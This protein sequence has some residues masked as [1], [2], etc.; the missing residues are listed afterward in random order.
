MNENDDDVGWRMRKDVDK[1]WVKERERERE[2]N[3]NI[4]YRQIII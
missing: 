4:Y 1:K 2:V 3:E